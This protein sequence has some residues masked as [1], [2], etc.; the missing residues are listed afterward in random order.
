[1][2]SARKMVLITPE[3]LQRLQ[4]VPQNNVAP[5]K[6]IE[7]QLDDVLADNALNDREK[8][9]KYTDLFQRF[10]NKLKE[11]NGP[12][13]IKLEDKD[14]KSNIVDAYESS[15]HP[16][17]D[18]I[19]REVP[20]LYQ[21]QA[22]LLIDRIKES[23]IIWN[24]RGDVSVNGDKIIGSNISDLV[25]DVVRKRKNVNPVG[26]EVFMNELKRINI[27]QEFIGNPD[28]KEYIARVESHVIRRSPSPD[29]SGKSQR[30]KKRKRVAKEKAETTI[31][32]WTHLKL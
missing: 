21:R 32:K 22:E 18:R 2:E 7:N 27:P 1:M 9:K 10:L 26:W 4:Q 13:S 25:N 30:E 6:S 17:V 15:K 3:T 12:I 16:N 14:V 20:K 29:W 11:S 28:R 24:E 31:R 8:W 5:I 19:V 23:K